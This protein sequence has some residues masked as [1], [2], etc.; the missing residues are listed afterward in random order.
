[1]RKVFREN[2]GDMSMGTYRSLLP[3]FSEIESVNI[4]GI[5]EP[6]LN[7]NIVEMVKLG[8]NHLPDHR[9]VYRCR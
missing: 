3:T 2:T 9:F 1:M 5:G 8:R 7:Q 4:I 6:L